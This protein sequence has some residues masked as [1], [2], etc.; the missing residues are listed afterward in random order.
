M[1]KR[2]ILSND[3]LNRYG[4]R[5]LTQG[6]ALQAYESNPVLLYMHDREMR[7]PVGTLKDLKV[8]PDPDNPGEFMLTG[9]PVFDTGIGDEFADMVAK[10]YEKGSLN[11][12]SIHASPIE[13]S[14]N[15]DL[16]KPG[17]SRPTVSKSILNEVSI[18]VVPGNQGATKLSAP[19]P[20]LSTHD[21][22]IS[23]SATAKDLDNILPLIAKN[24][25]SN[26]HDMKKIAL[27]LGLSGD[28]TEEQILEKIQEN[29]GN[30]DRALSLENGNKALTGALVGI[31]LKAGVIEEADKDDFISLASTAPKLAEKMV[32]KGISLAAKEDDKKDPSDQDIAL[33]QL[34]DDA[35]KE[36]KTPG[37]KKPE[38]I[39]LK[40][41][42]MTDKERQKLG[43]EDPKKFEAVL[44]AYLDRI[45]PDGKEA[46]KLD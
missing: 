44:N 4:F 27:A 31:A 16:L 5:V 14:D 35:E 9:E 37:S 23:L 29:D 3:Q 25:N 12:A 36:S 18:V 7:L 41:E 10:K 2:L 6:I 20:R 13:L 40:Y 28:A 33:S 8:E 22:E 46:I 11:A 38:D 17:Q 45:D 39:E 19:T 43:K 1:A 21:Y 24:Q 32:L 34:I 30:D 42:D 15:P 26:K